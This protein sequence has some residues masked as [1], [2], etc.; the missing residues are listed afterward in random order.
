MLLN[1][2]VLAVAESAPLLSLL[3][4]SPSIQLLSPPIPSQQHYQNRRR[5]SHVAA[6]YVPWE[7]RVL[8]IR[9]QAL[10][11]D[12]WRRALMGYYEL[13]REARS[14][15]AACAS[16]TREKG[17][18]ITLLW[19]GR[20]YDLG[21]RVAN[22]LVEMGDLKA[23]AMH[24]ASL[25]SASGN[26]AT[27]GEYLAAIMKEAL[28][29]LSLG[30]VASVR[31]ILERL[32]HGDPHS[33]ESLLQRKILAAL[34]QIA[35]GDYDGAIAGWKA[36]NETDL[37]SDGSLIGVLAEHNEAV[38]HLYADRMDEVSSIRQRSISH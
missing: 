37:S 20:L 8:A 6:T 16:A 30:D 14:N 29:W 17:E 15:I 31:G 34:L 5:S 10:S 13:A 1:L 33:D 7:L 27:S 18:D 35:D 32:S 9:L 11:C 21:V 25:K 36:L 12:D 28:V 22:A 19:R 26:A 2:T 24:L 38:C 23:A 3:F 4:D